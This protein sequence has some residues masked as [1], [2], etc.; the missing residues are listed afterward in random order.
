MLFH[1]W[2]SNQIIP[3]KQAATTAIIVTGVL[4]SSNGAAVATV[5]ILSVVWVVCG[6]VVKCVVV[7][8]SVVWCSVVWCSV[9]WCSVVWCSVVASV[10]LVV[11]SSKNLKIPFSI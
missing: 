8:C 6:S 11:G 4:F 9:V 10:V 2:I 7:W 5:V 1:T 3:I